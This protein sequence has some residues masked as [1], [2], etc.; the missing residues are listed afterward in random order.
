MD[1]P[2]EF[3][4]PISY[5]LMEDP[6]ILEDG[7][8]Y[9]RK[10]I[11]AWLRRKQ[12]SP[13]SNQFLRS[14]TLTPNFALRSAIE[15]WKVDGAAP[16]AAPTAPAAPAP[17]VAPLA[18]HLEKVGE[19][20]VQLRCEGGA[21]VETAVIAI[22]DRS[23][24]MGERCK[25][26]SP[27]DGKEAALFSRLDLVK[28]STI[29]VANLL[30]RGGGS[31]GI[32]SFSDNGRTEMSIH[33]MD[34]VGIREAERVVRDVTPGGGTNM[35]S[36]LQQALR[37]AEE[38]ATTHPMANIQLMFLSDGEETPDYSPLQGLTATLK[39]K[40][41]VFRTPITMSSFGFG[42]ALDT[43][44][45]EAICVDGGGTYGYISD[46]SMAGTVFINWCAAAL[47]VV[48]AH[49]KVGGVKV[50][51]I[52]AGQTRTLEVP[53][54]AVG[55]TLEVEYGSGM[56]RGKVT[57]A[58]KAG[59]ED[60]TANAAVWAKLVAELRRCTDVAGWDSLNA[61]GLRGLVDWIGDHDGGYRTA[62][63]SDLD[64][65]DAHK[66]QLLKAVSSR[67]VFE[68][69]GLNHL[70]S[71]R[72]GLETE[73]CVNFKDAALQFYTGDTFR[74]FQEAG[75]EL[76]D[77][78]PPPQPSLATYGT[79]GA[80]GG[81]GGTGAPLVSTISMGIFN[82]A[83]GGCF[84]GNCSVEMAEGRKF[85][86]QLR[87]GDVVRG[88]HRIVCVVRTVLAQEP[89]MVALGGLVIT[90][91][92]PVRTVQNNGETGPWRFPCD[93]G[94]TKRVPLT[95]YY[96]LVLES[97]HTVRIGNYDVCTLG[98]GFTDN[99]AIRHPYFGTH[100]VLD[101]L[102]REPGWCDGLVELRGRAT[103]RSPTTG[104]I[105][106]MT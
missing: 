71:Y 10:A 1:I 72:R 67:E 37:M 87:A 75:N 81:Y 27:T 38:Y 83:Q 88:G 4:C 100:A 91:W 103:Q 24:S 57:V 73:Q 59:E 92:H 90:P 17:S 54:V 26:P 94:E 86:S 77:S 42:Y 101:D 93:L 66:G 36:G 23:G 53:D 43:K 29:T 97:G 89:E 99:Y 63:L 6:V 48:A 51:S 19:G 32:V 41:G 96:N 31:L 61:S 85:V 15:R 12:T 13:L 28:H 79:Y 45:M 50:G 11:E 58:V 70:I 47:S 105:S 65:P 3:L 68:S 8:T 76:F 33:K 84:A 5:E 80:Y 46:G 44:K 18:F 40:L 39:K 74:G 62:V 21:P 106:R 60:A 55:S 14:P 2:N 95:A 82:T 98:H 34:S 104:L 20:L 102:A 16:A 9:E 25:R 56:A 35:W 78:L 22:L 64:H 30:G 52:L 49:V 7:H 69:W